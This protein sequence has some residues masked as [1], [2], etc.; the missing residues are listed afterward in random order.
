M[1]VGE[2]AL[3]IQ[4]TYRDFHIINIC[5]TVVKIF[6]TRYVLNEVDEVK[7]EGNRAATLSSQGPVEP[8]WLKARE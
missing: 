5:S 6:E 7:L 1:L 2:K 3:R 4:A 8:R